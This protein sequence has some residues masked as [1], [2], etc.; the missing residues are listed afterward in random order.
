VDGWKVWTNA[1]VT[2]KSRIES[3][4]VPVRIILSSHQTLWIGTGSTIRFDGTNILVEKGSAQLDAAGKYS[5]AGRSTYG[6]LAGS[7]AA[8]MSRAA[9]IPKLYQS[10]QELRSMSQRP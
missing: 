3:G 1:S 7:D 2:S 9:Q 10:L 8:E 6:L 4:I 5:L